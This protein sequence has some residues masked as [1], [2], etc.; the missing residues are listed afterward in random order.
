MLTLSSRHRAGPAPHAEECEPCIA[1]AEAMA[2]QAAEVAKAVTAVAEAAA[3]T[4]AALHAEEDND[5][6]RTHVS[7]SPHRCQHASPSPERRRGLRGRRGSPVILQV[8]K[9]L[10]GA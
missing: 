8:I 9:E 10:R 1:V 6:E 5:K 4:A 3:A 2:A 7:R